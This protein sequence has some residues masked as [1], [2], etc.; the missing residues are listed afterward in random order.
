MTVEQIFSGLAA[1]MIKGL[2]IHEQMIEYYNFLALPGYAKCHKYHYLTE[3]KGYMKLCNFYITR[4]CKLIP[5][6]TSIEN[7]NLIPSAW[8]NHKREDV[9]TNTMRKAVESG[10]KQWIDWEKETK[11]LYQ[12]SYKELMQL[13]QVSAAQFIKCYI[14]AVDEELAEA[15]IYYLHKQAIDFNAGTIIGEQERKKECYTK[16]IKKIFS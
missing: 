3:T 9:D 14:C 7:P 8:Y 10:L 16:K 5:E 2:M 11:E 6:P 15:K 4:Y 13:E 1:H 12:T